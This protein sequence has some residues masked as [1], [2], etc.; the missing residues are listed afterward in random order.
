MK[1][2]KRRKK[3][4]L[5][6]EFFDEISSHLPENRRNRILRDKTHGHALVRFDSHSSVERHITD[7]FTLV[8]IG[9]P[10]HT[11]LAEYVLD[12][13]AFG[14]RERAHV[15]HEAE[16][17]HVDFGEHFDATSRVQ[18]SNVLRSGDNHGAI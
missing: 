16:Y 18:E 10:A 15:L 3:E 5:S 17:R 1:R 11:L 9:E 6:I 8:L 14:T 7:H 4:R 2:N 12:M 13:A